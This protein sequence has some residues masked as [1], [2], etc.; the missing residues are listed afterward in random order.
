MCE[1]FE[2]KWCS[3]DWKGKICVQFA[4]ARTW[5]LSK[6]LSN[7]WTD[8]KVA[9]VAQP[10]PRLHI[11]PFGLCETSERSRKHAQRSGCFHHRL[12]KKLPTAIAISFRQSLDQSW[13]PVELFLMR[14]VF[15]FFFCNYLLWS[16]PESLCEQVAVGLSQRNNA[17]RPVGSERKRHGYSTFQFARLLLHRWQS[18]R[19][20]V[21]ITVARRK[22][23][24]L[25][26]WLLPRRSV[27]C[28]RPQ[29]P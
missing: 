1:H 24:K 23:V 6:T 18:L 27:K 10:P 4:Q 2:R 13:T 28:C 5:S 16:A 3:T 8:V 21:P 12:E 11:R 19:R 20:K 29:K 25:W 22:A 15:L 7:W 26:K 17:R 9:H 14:N